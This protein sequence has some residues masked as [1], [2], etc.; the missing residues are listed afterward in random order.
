MTRQ[1]MPVDE[2]ERAV[3]AF[4]QAWLGTR[5]LPKGSTSKDAAAV[6]QVDKARRARKALLVAAVEWQGSVARGHAEWVVKAVDYLGQEVALMR[7]GLTGDDLRRYNTEVEDEERAVAGFIT[8]N[9]LWL[10]DM[11]EEMAQPAENNVID[12][13]TAYTVGR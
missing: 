12:M 5:A 11:L 3:E 9:R 10:R 2:R 1:A 13:D 6:L 8:R 7:R 4:A